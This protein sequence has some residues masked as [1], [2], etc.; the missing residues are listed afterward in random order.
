MPFGFTPTCVGTILEKTQQLLDLD[1]KK[2]LEVS[3]DSVRFSVSADRKALL[4]RGTVQKECIASAE[5][6]TEHIPEPV[7]H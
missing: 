6:F 4:S 5:L 7:S 2:S 1:Q 3:N